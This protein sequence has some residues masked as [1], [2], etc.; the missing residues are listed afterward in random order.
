MNIELLQNQVK[1]AKRQKEGEA[2]SLMKL[3]I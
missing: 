1:D 2:K 3:R